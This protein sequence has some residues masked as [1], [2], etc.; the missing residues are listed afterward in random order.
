MLYLSSC[1]HETAV[2]GNVIPPKLQGFVALES[3]GRR[4][5][6][7]SYSIYRI[8]VKL[9][10]QSAK[11]KCKAQNVCHCEPRRGEAIFLKG[12]LRSLRL[13]RNDTK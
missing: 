1:N 7:Y 9:K 4:S 3:L 11:F 2:V 12:L 10:A 8:S 13:A 5:R 6:H